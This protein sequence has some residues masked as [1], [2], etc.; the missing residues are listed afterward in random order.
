MNAISQYSMGVVEVVWA[1]GL[2]CVICGDFQNTAAELADAQ[3]LFSANLEIVTNDLLPTCFGSTPRAI[4]H[5]LVSAALR[6]A[7]AA[8][9]VQ[10]SVRRSHVVI[11]AKMC[12]RPRTIMGL[13][14][15]AHPAWPELPDGGA[16]P[17]DTWGYGEK[18][19]RMRQRL[20]V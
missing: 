14:P 13:Q 4:D 20:L 8:V 6:P 12:C 5:C 9:A 16:L 19:C 3:L 7:I 10:P 15:C 17:E 11:V 2:P 18:S 1:S